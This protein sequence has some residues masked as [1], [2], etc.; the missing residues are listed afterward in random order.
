MAEGI[1]QLQRD[2]PLLEGVQ[3]C[4]AQV[5]GTAVE[6]QLIQRWFAHQQGFVNA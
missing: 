1:A 2:N 3:A 4:V 5:A 6:P